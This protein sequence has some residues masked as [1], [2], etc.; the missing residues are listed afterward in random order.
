MYRPVEIVTDMKRARVNTRAR[1]IAAAYEVFAEVGFQAA[2]I[3]QIC[4]RAGFTRG[5]FYSNFESKVDLFI[6]LFEDHSVDLIERIRE[7]AASA[8]AEGG[9][10]SLLGYFTDLTEEDRNWYLISTEFTLYAVRNPDAAEMLAERDRKL[11]EEI[12]PLIEAAIERTGRKPLVPVA[13]MARGVVALAE[14]ASGQAY[15][16]PESLPPGS[17]E[18]ALIPLIFL[19]VTE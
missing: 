3:E 8:P 14:G 4:E 12:E 16:E 19:G 13:L 6:A 17:L 1:L 9:V 10:E 15:V 2:T 5:A 11:R 7:L 18:R